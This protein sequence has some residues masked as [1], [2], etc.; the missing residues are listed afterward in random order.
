MKGLVIADVVKDGRIDSASN[1]RFRRRGLHPR[2]NGRRGR[3][4]LRVR[5]HG[6]RAVLV[7]RL[8]DALR[9]RYPPLAA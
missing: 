7:E 1:D 5:I 3:A 9:E 4:Q 6:D 8:V 2:E